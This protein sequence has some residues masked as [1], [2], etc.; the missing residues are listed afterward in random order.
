MKKYVLLLIVCSVFLQATYTRMNGTVTDSETGL[1][2][3]DDYSDNGGKIKK[4]GWQNAISYC[5]N[6]DAL[7]YDDWRLPNVNELASIVDD[8]K[9][10]EPFDVA[11]SDRAISDIFNL[12]LL[13]ITYPWFW[14]STTHAYNNGENAWGVC[15]YDGHISSHDK[16]ENYRNVRCVRDSR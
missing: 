4:T 7:G 11:F 3:Q 1:M 14:T 2:W 10:T 16:T 13:H 15:F 12:E 6:L 8:T 9:G 5:N